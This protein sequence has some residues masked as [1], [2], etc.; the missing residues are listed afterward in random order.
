MVSEEIEDY[1]KTIYNL[2][3]EKGYARIKDIASQLKVKPPSVSQMIRKLAKLG[4]VEYERY[5][6]VKLTQKGKNTAREIKKRHGMISKFLKSIGVPTK[7]ADDDACKIE[8]HLH[9][10]T[11]RQLVEFVKKNT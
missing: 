11:M 7:I 8:H 5:G 4:Y 3:S 1:L 9:P 2:S 6:G 10:K